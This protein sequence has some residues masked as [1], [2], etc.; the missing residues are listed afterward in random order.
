VTRILIFPIVLVG[1]VA[2]ALQD[3]AA[4]SRGLARLEIKAVA[5][6]G[7]TVDQLARPQCPG[8]AMCA[9]HHSG[10]ACPGCEM[11]QTKNR[12]H[13]AH[14]MHHSGAGMCP[15]CDRGKAAS[16]RM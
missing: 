8:G 11:R 2:L 9:Q 15:N 10:Q 5:V 3:T 6:A 1:L 4:S 12:H 16:R 7:D 13:C 14:T